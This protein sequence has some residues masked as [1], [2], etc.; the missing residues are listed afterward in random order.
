MNW[1]ERYVTI[2]V[3]DLVDGT[4]IFAFIVMLAVWAGIGSHSI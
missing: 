4:A 2:T 1:R 3:G